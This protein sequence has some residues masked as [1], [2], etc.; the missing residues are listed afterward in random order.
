MMNAER[1]RCAQKDWTGE[2]RD[3]CVYFGGN[4]KRVRCDL[5]V[6]EI[7][8]V[9]FIRVDPS[10][11][12]LAASWAIET[13]ETLCMKRSPGF[14]EADWGIE[15]GTGAFNSVTK[16]HLSRLFAQHSLRHWAN[17]VSRNVAHKGITG[18]FQ[19]PIAD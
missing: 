3:R 6:E 11:A 4:G 1:R 2:K 15:N 17:L 8:P 7:A 14:P 16:S 5:S 19:N 12:F 18:V 10:L 13:Q 9:P